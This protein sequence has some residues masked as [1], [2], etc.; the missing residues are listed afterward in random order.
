[1]ID[2]DIGYGTQ[3]IC[4]YNWGVQGSRCSLR[5]AMPDRPH[6]LGHQDGASGYIVLRCG[7][8]TMDVE[9]KAYNGEGIEATEARLV[10]CALVA[11]SSSG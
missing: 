6:K 10:V 3:S 7:Q 11:A 8:S 5:S 4:L 9:G 1:M 2:Q